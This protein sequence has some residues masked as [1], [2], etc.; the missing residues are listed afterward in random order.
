MKWVAAFLAMSSLSAVC[1]AASP[2][3]TILIRGARVF[4]GSGAPA[5]VGD[6]LV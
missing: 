2:D 1:A 5:T 6:V 3:D 4:D